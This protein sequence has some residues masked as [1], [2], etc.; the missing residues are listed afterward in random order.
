MKINTLLDV[1][2]RIFEI[3]K[4]RS[5]LK[6]SSFLI[7]RKFKC[8]SN[9]NDNIKQYCKKNLHVSPSKHVNLKIRGGRSGLYDI[10]LLSN[11]TTTFR[12]PSSIRF[13]DFTNNIIKTIYND[14][15]KFIVDGTSKLAPCFKTPKILEKHCGNSEFYIKEE[16]IYFK[17]VSDWSDTDRTFVIKTVLSDYANYYKTVVFKKS[18]IDTTDIPIFLKRELD[19]QLIDVNRYYMKALQ[20]GDLTFNNLLLT[21]DND[22]YFIDFE[23]ED[24]FF[25]LYDIFWIIQNDYIYNNN[26]L[27]LKKYIKGEYDKDFA[28]LFSSLGINYHPAEKKLYFEIFLCE[29]FDKRV[30][31]LS[32]Q[33]RNIG[34]KSLER[35]YTVVK[36]ISDGGEI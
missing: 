26:I 14:K 1:I 27:L 9:S 35:L 21:Y 22:V 24:D 32:G 10:M 12:R 8:V 20:H 6:G 17:P 18:Q 2:V 11:S 29:M 16:L 36:I 30:R 23:H 28:N 33:N 15:N 3:Q 25:F 13:F 34:I 31:P 7:D 5:L 4:H 19:N